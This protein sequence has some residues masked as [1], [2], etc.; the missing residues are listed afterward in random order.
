MKTEKSTR[1]YKLCQQILSLTGINLQRQTLIGYTELHLVPTSDAQFRIISLNCKQ[2][3][4]Y[5]VVINDNFEAQFQ[6]F[7]P[8][9]EVCQL[10]F[11]KRS[12]EDFSASHQT[13]LRLV[14]PDNNAGELKIRIPPEASYLIIKDRPFRVGIE[15]S[16]EQ[17]N[18]G[19]HFVSP[20]VDGAPTEPSQMFT[21]GWQNSSRLWFP[22]IDSFAEVCTWKLEF[23][24][25]ESLTAVSCGDLVEVVYT[26]DMRRK[27]FYYSQTV[28][29]AAPNIALA[30]GPFEVYVDPQ[31][32]EV[33]HFCLPPLLPLLKHVAK[34]FREALQFYEETLGS[35]FVYSSYK[36]VFVDEAY[37]DISSFA[38]L[39]IMSVNFLHSYVQIDQTYITRQALANAIS[40]Q[41]FSSF[42][43]RQNWNDA[44]LTFGI[45]DYLGGLY[46]KKFFGNNEYRYHIMKE[47]EAVVE[48]E[49]KHGGIILDPSQSPSP[50]VFP[51]S[52]PPPKAIENQFHFPLDSVHTVSPEY[53]EV[54]RKKAHLIIRML[55]LRI[56]YQMLMQVFNKQ[57]SLATAAAKKEFAQDQWSSMLISTEGFTKAIHTVT[58]K[59]MAAFIDQWVHVAGHAKFTMKFVFNR[60]RNTVELEL[61]QDVGLSNSALGTKRYMGP[62][63]VAL[64]ELDGT[65]RHTLQIESN[66]AKA[67]LTCHSKSRKNKKKKIPLFTGEEV[68][69]DLS[70]MD[71]DSPVLWIRMDPDMSLIR[72]CEVHQ[73]D[74]Q[75]QYQLKHERDIVAQI[76]ACRA[77]ERFP[78]KQ[79][80]LAISEVL[81]NEQAFY[82]VRTECCFG[83]A[84]VT[85]MLVM[86]GLPLGPIGVTLTS[87][88]QSLFGSITCKHI[89][90]QNNFDNLQHYFLQKALPVAIATQRTQY[91]V[92]PTE[93]MNFLTNL[94][95]YNDNSKNRFTDAYYRA[96]LLEALGETVSPVATAMIGTQTSSDSLSRETREILEEVSRA[97]NLEK[98]MPCY[99]YVITVAALKTVRRLQKNGHLPSKS[100]LF[101]SYA[102]HGQFLDVRL[103]ALECIV[104]ILQSDKKREDMEFL[105]RIVETDPEA[106]V[107]HCLVRMMVR[108]P[109]FKSDAGRPSYNQLDSEALVNR[110][111]GL[112]NSQICNDARLRCDIHDLYVTLYGRRR[113][114][115]LHN[116]P[117][118]S[119]LFA[120]MP[121]MKR[122]ASSTFGSRLDF[123]RGIKSEPP[124]MI[125][126]ETLPESTNILDVHSIQQIKQDNISN[127]NSP[128]ASGML[129]GR[130][131]GLEEMYRSQKIKRKKEKKKKSKKH[132][133]KKER[134]DSLE[135]PTTATDGGLSSDSS[136]PLTPGKGSIDIDDSL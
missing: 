80:R 104:Q 115:C 61:H 86:S 39:T 121:S 51:G 64:Q 127:P 13:A 130:H 14:D 97:L 31:M 46:V 26:P 18:G 10:D 114:S 19:I 102:E 69:M 133:H 88:F 118:F 134:A 109:P 65:F 101:Y 68:D 78:T 98:L 47:M 70:A 15:F 42:I 81:I 41:Y 95:K 44:W 124:Q 57:L 6:Y 48:Y 37:Q 7:D 103:A 105:L 23:T 82:R 123:E 16:L 131:S 66:P 110:L 54:M 125:M 67:D 50:T 73:P 9:L 107:R 117:L 17:P 3:R 87:Y 94:F 55:E 96:S 43:S 90:K 129:D 60:K 11:K 25:D 40:Q 21:F 38:S 36:V 91:N 35:R 30:V 132:K 84:K 8:T 119:P 113:P 72:S 12:A 106:Y 49:Q 45:A 74:F 135:R 32:H 75:W 52:V 136:G 77:L 93:V 128:A 53:V 24:V 108:Q 92:A 29:T 4:V 99:K 126:E 79:T 56:G 20:K 116:A 100:D 76:E 111:W 27:T 83:L 120:N 22:C 58:G 89:I 5:K 112:M 34:Y 63:V 85:N 62:L 1:P 59:D 71:P 122:P 2:C 33:T 28:P